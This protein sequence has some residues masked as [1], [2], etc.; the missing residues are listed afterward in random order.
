MASQDISKLSYTELRKLAEDALTLANS[1]RAEE[2][3]VLADAY[4]KKTTAA[5][6]SI[7]EAIEAL[8]P[9]WPKKGKASSTYEVKYRDPANAGNTY[10]GRGKR[11]DWLR[12][13][14]EQGRQLEEFAV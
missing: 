12:K 6:F 7:E 2:V 3:K 9:Y 14:L 13:Y 1:K 8:K 4:A 11:P 10:G 5:G